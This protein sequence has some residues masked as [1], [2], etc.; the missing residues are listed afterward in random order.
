LREAGF[1]VVWAGNFVDQG[2]FEIQDQV[3][4]CV[5]CFDE[6]LLW[7]SFDYVSSK[8][9]NV[10]AYLINGMSN[11]RRPSDGLAQRPVHHTEALEDR[12]GK[13]VIGHDTA[14]Y[15]RIFKTLGISPEIKLGRLLSSLEATE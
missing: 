7:R 9:P 11:Y 5:W 10:D 12:L 14:L 1:D 15:W 6:S 13:L 3:N 2:W 8:A 4:R